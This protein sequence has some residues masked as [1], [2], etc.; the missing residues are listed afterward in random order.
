MVERQCSAESD[1]NESLLTRAEGEEKEMEKK[2]SKTKEIAMLVMVLTL[3]FFALC[4]DTILYPFFPKVAYDRGISNTQIGVVI[5]TFDF[6]RFVASP[7]FGSLVSLIQQF[8]EI[9]ISVFVAHCV[10]TLESFGKASLT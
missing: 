10:S 8:L 7:I 6:A 2:F 3:Q 1:E 4:S 5:S 9:S